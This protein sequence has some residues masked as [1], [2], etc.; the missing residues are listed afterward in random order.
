MND[1][2]EILIFFLAFFLFAPALAW[3]I[4]EVFS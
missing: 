2:G 1:E 4:V 3:V